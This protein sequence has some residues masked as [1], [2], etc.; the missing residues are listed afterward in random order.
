[1]YPIKKSTNITRIQV[2]L[3]ILSNF[4]LFGFFKSMGGSANTLPDIP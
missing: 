1:M 4:E 2:I 3:D